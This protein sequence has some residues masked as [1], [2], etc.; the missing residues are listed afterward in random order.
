M[1]E[2]I[3]DDL[4]M[5]P[6][7]GDA[8][9]YVRKNE[10][11]ETIGTTRMYIDGSLNSG[12]PEFE[13]LSGKTLTR[14][15]SKPRVYDK[16]DFF[17]AP[18]DTTKDAVLSLTQT[19]YFINLQLL[20]NSA[21]FANYRRARAL[22]SWI[23]HSRSDV[24][25][26]AN[27]AAQ[28]P[29][30]TFGPSNIKVLNDSVKYAKRETSIALQYAPP[31]KSSVN[32]RV[33][34]DASFVT[35]DGL[36]SQLGIVLLLCDFGDNAHII[37]YRSNKTRKVVRS[38]MGGE[39][40]A[41]MEGFN[42]PFSFARDL[43]AVLGRIVLVYMYTDPKQLFDASTRGNQTTERRLMVEIMAVRQAYRR[44]ETTA[45]RLVRG[46]DNQADELSK[47][48]DKSALRRL[49]AK[50]KDHTKVVQWIERN[51][52]PVQFPP[53]WKGVGV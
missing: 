24:A 36:A 28:V 14:F 44:F 46:E 31:D 12:T 6:V 29:E 19:C 18:I 35:N 45:I 30:K 50:E 11:D 23:L 7:P 9:L 2:H 49:F 10:P 53:H 34:T 47:I 39:V 40:A 43:Q 1:D 26:T 48:K 41:F 16:S 22:F 21:T 52:A 37:D 13:K 51:G 27:L 17:G 33:Y 32:L 5:N 38:T 8:S 4:Q 15:E 25:V 3:V 20:S 42:H